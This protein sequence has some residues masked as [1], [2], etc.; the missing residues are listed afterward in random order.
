MIEKSNLSGLSQLLETV[1]QS[2]GIALMFFFGSTCVLGGFIIG[3]LCS[4]WFAFRAYKEKK[5]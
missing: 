1:A 4:I 3:I 2:D 5:Q